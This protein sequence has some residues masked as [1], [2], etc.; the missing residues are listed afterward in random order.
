MDKFINEKFYRF[1]ILCLF[2]TIRLNEQFY[3]IDT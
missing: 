1:E 3:T 2:M